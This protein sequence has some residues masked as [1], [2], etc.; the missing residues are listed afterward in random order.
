VGK[1]TGAQE[2]PGVNARTTLPLMPAFHVR[3]KRRIVLKCS[4]EQMG[5]FP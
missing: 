4:R 1:A 3:I 2:V 5:R